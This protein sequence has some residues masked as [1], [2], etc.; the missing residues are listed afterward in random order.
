M[1]FNH[2]AP[3]DLATPRCYNERTKS[4]KTAGGANLIKPFSVRIVKLQL[5]YMKLESLVIADHGI[6][7]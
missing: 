7:R 1:T 2:H 4:C 3:Y 6:A 5:A